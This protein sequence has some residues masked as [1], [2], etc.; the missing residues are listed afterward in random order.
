MSTFHNGNSEWRRDNGSN[1]GS[2]K[3]KHAP[4][5][6]LGHRSRYLKDKEIGKRGKTV[7]K[8]IG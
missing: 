4:I 7:M 2:S 6:Q 3:M 1:E 8:S 5:E